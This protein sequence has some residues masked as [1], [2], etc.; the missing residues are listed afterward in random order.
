MRAP[1]ERGGER[2]LRSGLLVSYGGHGKTKTMKMNSLLRSTPSALVLGVLVAGGACTKKNVRTQ[3]ANSKSSPAM[4]APV[5]KD[6]NGKP[7][8]SGDSLP[9]GIE[10]GKLDM[11][12]RKIFDQVVNHESSACGKGHSLLYSVMHDGSCRAS[13]YAVRYVARLADA[14]A[15]EAEIGEK[16]EQRF[17]A[18]RV[19][20]IDLSQAP[21]KGS[22]S[23][24]VKLVEFADYECTHCKEAQALMVP[25]LAAYPQEVTVYFKHFPLGGH[26]NSLN[27]ALAA[28]AAQKQGKFWQ[29]NE[30]VWQNSEHLTPAVLEG[31]ARELALDFPRWIADVGS[32]EV[33][34]Q[35]QRDRTEARELEIRRTPGIF[36]NGRR[37][38]DEIDL[39]SLKDWIDEELGR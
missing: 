5:P 36:I 14:G 27:A 9:P 33:R 3:P 24:R 38:T 8:V 18:P 35:V 22:P 34:G 37:F 29:F 23:G 20:Y 31:I 13:F 1:G 7:V 19:P 21:S 28:V 25:L 11:A 39:P 30:K 4:L 2:A 16:L 12:K 6:K 26:V 15:S 32:D 17:R 10:V